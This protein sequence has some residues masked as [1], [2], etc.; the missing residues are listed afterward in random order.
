MMRCLEL[1]HEYVLDRVRHGSAHH[2]P[3][4][5][6]FD[7]FCRDVG[8]GGGSGSG[9]V[10]RRLGGDMGSSSVQCM[11]GGDIGSSG[12]NSSSSTSGGS[13]SSSGGSGGSGVQRR[14]LERPD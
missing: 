14:E 12:G 10:H 9:N 3:A 7:D 11:L 13:G 6:V 5:A 8:S 4:H 1:C 2:F